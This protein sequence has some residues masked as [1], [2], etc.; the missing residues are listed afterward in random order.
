MTR[1]VVITQPTYLPWLG[2][3]EL[4][5]RADV[6]VALDTVQFDRR[7][8]QCRN[9]LRRRDGKTFWLTV[10]VR[11]A[12]RDCPI[13]DIRVA[14]GDWQRKHLASIRFAL[15]GAPHFDS[16]FRRVEAW[17]MREHERLV[18]LTSSGIDLFCELL[19]LTPQ[20]LRA[21]ELG[22]SGR[23]ADLLLE[24]C[25]ELRAT[26]YYSAAGARAYLEPE[27]ARFRSAGI[28]VT[29]QQWEHP[30]Y[31]QRGDG[32]TSHLNI[33]D[34]MMNLGPEATRAA[35]V[36]GAAEGGSAAGQRERRQ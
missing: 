13:R 23:R 34:P 2:Y 3:F 18:D 25:R 36:G 4:L 10:P 29:F 14:N 12:A 11:R 20:R 35:I 19:R 15:G 5:A 30:R 28:D 33:L 24:I 9:R 7:S 16:V 1:S 21:S 27:V 8:W 31:D 6:F 17:L 26:H 32:F 22:A